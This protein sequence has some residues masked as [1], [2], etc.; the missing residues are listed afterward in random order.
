[1]AAS[2]E[3]GVLRP[4]ELW[5]WLTLGSGGAVLLR[6]SAKAARLRRLFLNILKAKILKIG[7]K[8]EIGS[9][10]GFGRGICRRVMRILDPAL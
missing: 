4:E 2:G 5:M 9:V 1:M 8:N 6:R 3:E 10:H 7:D